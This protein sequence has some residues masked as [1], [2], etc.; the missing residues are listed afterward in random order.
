MPDGSTERFYTALPGDFPAVT[1]HLPD[2]TM[3]SAPIGDLCRQYVDA[4][5]VIVADAEAQF[6]APQS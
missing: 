6:H 2:S 3:P 5:T 1:L 4:L